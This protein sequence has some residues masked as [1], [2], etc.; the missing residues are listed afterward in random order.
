MVEVQRQCEQTAVGRGRVSEGGGQRAAMAEECE[1][2]IN[3][4]TVG[5]VV[6]PASRCIRTAHVQKLSHSHMRPLYD[7]SAHVQNAKA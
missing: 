2:D 3:V 5:S 7:T 6:T 1:V 4:C